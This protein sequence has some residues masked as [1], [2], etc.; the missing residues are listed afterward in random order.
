M[1]TPRFV[2]I[3]AAMISFG[4]AEPER[5]D[6]EVKPPAEVPSMVEV[7]APGVISTER[8]ET[9]PAEDPKHGSLWFSVY[10]ESF[11]AQT[12]MFARPTESGWAAHE[13][14][15]FSGEWNDRAPRFSPDGAT[16]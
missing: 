1:K 3:A 9:F 15:P 6:A 7:V 14:A 4:C 2:W 11:G 12:I 10:D 16:L 13:V 8:N 5:P